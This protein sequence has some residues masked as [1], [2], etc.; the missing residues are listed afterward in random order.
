MKKQLL[1]LCASAF[2][3]HATQAQNT[4]TL[5]STVLEYRTVIDGLNVPWE[6]IWGPDSMIWATER[7]GLVSHINPT[8]GTRTTLLDLTA[9]VYDQSESGL[10]GMLLHPDFDNTPHVFLAYTYLVGGVNIRERLVRYEYNGSALVNPDTLLEN[11][12]GNTTHIGSRMLILPDNTLLMTTGDAQNTSAPQNVA[13]LSGKVLRMNLDGSVPADNPMAGSLVWT[14]GHRNPQGL[15]LA[16]NGMLYCSEHG[17][18]SDDELHIL[19]AG[20]NYGWPTVTGYCDSPPEMTFC[21]DSNV[22]EPLTAW[23]PT[24]APSDIAWYDHPSIPEFE[25]KL[26]MT[27]L[28]DKEFIAFGF[29]AT[30]DT[31]VSQNTYFELEFNRLR[32][33]CVAPDGRIFIATNGANWSNTDPFTHEIIELRNPNYIPSGLN[34]APQTLQAQL[35]PNP[36]RQGQPIRVQL[37][38][39]T[40]A[41]IVI[42]DVLGRIVFSNDQVQTGWLDLPLEAGMYFYQINQNGKSKSGKLM[43][44]R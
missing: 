37:P 24:I 19:M 13:H 30:G 10:L 44:A 7:H 38:A 28:K 33:V 32:D 2:A 18:T 26:L 5:D 12:I 14:W 22:V 34:V 3:A 40:P 27:V 36:V 11:I 29:N 23:T 4:T 31:I 17:P 1:F 15:C 35:A 25:N 39:E 16:P 9:S 20:R 21:A 41:N 6:I 42:A 8:T 43:V